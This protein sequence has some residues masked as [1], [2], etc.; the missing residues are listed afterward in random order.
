MSLSDGN[1]MEEA[2]LFCTFLTL[3]TCPILSLTTGIHIAVDGGQPGSESGHRVSC[4]SWPETSTSSNS[5][6]TC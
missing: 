5:D 2:K 4:G 1:I 3:Q 6:E